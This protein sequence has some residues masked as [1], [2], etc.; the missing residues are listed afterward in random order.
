MK[1]DTPCPMMVVKKQLLLVLKVIGKEDPPPASGNGPPHLEFKG[2]GS[3]C[4]GRVSGQP[5][6]QQTD[7]EDEQGSP[8]L[9]FP[10][11]KLT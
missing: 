8:E 4:G 2:Q 6:K 9:I 11:L 3:H 10:K 5:I 1:L 7:P